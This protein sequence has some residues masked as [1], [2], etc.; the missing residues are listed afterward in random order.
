MWSLFLFFL[1]SLHLSTLVRFWFSCWVF[2]PFS[3]RLSLAHFPFFPKQSYDFIFISSPCVLSFS[4]PISCILLYSWFII[5]LKY[6][7]HVVRLETM[8]TCPF[9]CSIRLLSTGMLRVKH[10]H[11]LFTLG[12]SRKVHPC[13]VFLKN[14]HALLLERGCFCFSLVNVIAHTSSVPVSTP[15][16][17]I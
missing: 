11:A 1:P 5:A 14:V 2:E 7:I 16:L 9:S 13:S 6:S 8:L 17:L 15:V 3:C 4:L 10:G 12:C